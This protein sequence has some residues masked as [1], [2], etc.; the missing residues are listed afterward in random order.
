MGGSRAGRVDLVAEVPV[1]PGA[2]SRLRQVLR[3]LMEARGVAG[4][5]CVVLAGDDRLRELKREHWGED[6]PTDVLS[7]PAWEPG[8]PFVPPHL[9]DVVISVPTAAAQAAERGH[10]LEVELAVLASH[11]LTHLL[12]LDHETP[13]GWAPFE[14]AEREALKR[15]AALRGT[16]P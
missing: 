10:D 9:G 2:R 8:D 6:A 14:A 5:V 4:E 12:G 11:G 16:A 1:P 13:A 7:F 15:L 3:A